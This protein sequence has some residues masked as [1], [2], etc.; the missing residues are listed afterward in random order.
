MN[1]AAPEVVTV[2]LTP[3]ERP[4]V[5]VQL[6]LFE[7]AAAPAPPAADAPKAA[8]SPWPAAGITEAGHWGSRDGL[9]WERVEEGKLIVSPDHFVMGWIVSTPA[10]ARRAM[11]DGVRSAVAPSEE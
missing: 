2:A 10:E 3:P 5:P 11:R 6:D 4:A 7:W 1:S 8:R 9:K